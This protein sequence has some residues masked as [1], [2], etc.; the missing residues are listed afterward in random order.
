MTIKEQ[1]RDFV[2]Q[3]FKDKLS[4]S[5]LYHNFNH[6]VGVVEAVEKL[7]AHSD[8]TEQ[9]KEVLIIAA[10]FHDTG[11]TKDYNNHEQHS[12]G[13]VTGYLKEKG[14]DD[15]YIEK[16]TGLINATVYCYEPKNLSE[17]IICDAD[18]S[19]LISES[20]F[21]TSE[22]LRKEWEMT[23]NKFFTDSEWTKGNLELFEKH[24]YHTDFALSEWV[25]KKQKNAEKLA[26]I[27]KQQQTMDTPNDK[28]TK[29]KNKAEKSERGGE[30]MF[31]ITLTN[32][33]RL[34][35]IADSKAN[36]LLSVN[37][38]IISIALSTLIPKLD[39]P[40]NAHL[41]I[42]TFIMLMFSVICIIFAILSTRPKI[43][44]GKFT[45]EDI[46]NKKVNL[47][48]FGNFYKMPYEEYQWAINELLKDKEYM[49]NSMTK[50]LYYL[51]LVLE[52]KYRLLRITYNLF[53][54]GIIASVIAFVY[55]FHSM[56][57]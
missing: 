53:M 49:N 17:K 56:S 13:I 37:A 41:I 7:A 5:F 55:A 22:A 21:E 52:R 43:T 11:Y 8:L 33:I 15:D 47:L 54:V 38:I 31:K 19:H 35:E 25:P 16:V 29:K 4:A 9:E 57:A 26:E 18:Y 27:L 42:P 44:S 39:S 36:I 6:T 45:R 30:T 40:T 2:F 50:D 3:L 51:G 28:E 32:H 24:H 14:I 23:Q 48:F 46:D 12:I 1:A 20:Y 10:W 34:S